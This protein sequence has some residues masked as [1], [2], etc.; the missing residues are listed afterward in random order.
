[1]RQNG[2]HHRQFTANRS[3]SRVIHPDDMACVISCIHAS[4]QRLHQTLIVRA[5]SKIEMRPFLTDGPQN[6]RSNR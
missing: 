2:A 6:I 5:A 1:M 4:K 3:S